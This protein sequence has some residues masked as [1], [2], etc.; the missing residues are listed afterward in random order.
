[1]V[2][3]VGIFESLEPLIRFSRFVRS[4]SISAAVRVLGGGG[5]GG[6]GD[7]EMIL[8]GGD[9][10]RVGSGLHPLPGW[11]CPRQNPLCPH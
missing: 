1:M 7:L 4:I 3:K 10:F 9:M 2:E 5:G 8:L 6:D 11:I